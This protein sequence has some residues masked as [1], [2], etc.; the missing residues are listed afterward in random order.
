MPII[1]KSDTFKI[2][3][4]FFFTICLFWFFILPMVRSEAQV[5]IGE[6]IALKVDEGTNMAI[7]LSPDQSSIVLDLQGTLWMLPVQGGEATPL[8]DELGDCR[9]PVWAP[10]GNEIAFQSYRDGNYHIWKIN[11]DGSGLTQLTFGIFDDREP[12][13]APS[14]SSLLFSSD[15]S[16]NYDI[17]EL[18]LESGDLNQRTEDP[19]NDYYPSCS[20][21]GK[22]MVFV[23]DR[24]VKE[25]IYTKMGG[26]QEK[27]VFQDNGKLMAP[28]W[29]PGGERLVFNHQIGGESYLKSIDL[30]SGEVD[31]FSKPGED[32]FPF[33]VSWKSSES[34]LFTVD[35]KIKAAT[36]GE[37]GVK[38]IPFEANLPFSRHDYPRKRYDFLENKPKSVKGI[39]SPAVSPDGK[40]V[41]FTALGDLYVLDTSQ[42]EPQSLTNDKFIEIDPVWSPDG[43][44]V[45]YTSDKL[46][47]MD[48]WVKDLETGEETCLINE[49]DHVKFP[50]W[51]PDGTRIAFYQADPSAYR[52]SLLSIADLKSGTKVAVIGGLFDPGRATWSPDG[53]KIAYSSLKAYSSRF[54]EGISGIS[55][56]DIQSQTSEFMMP[57]PERTLGTRGVNGPTWSPDGSHLAF[58]LDNVLWTIPVD[59][60]GSFIGPSKRMTNELA[61]SPTW[62]GDG[63][64]LVY[65]ATDTL[66]QVFLEDGTRKSIPMTFDWNYD[67][68]IGQY[69]I[70]AGRIFDGKSETYLENMDVL[71][72]GNVIKSIEPHVGDREGKVIDASD[73]TLMPGLF[74]MHTHQNALA[75]EELGRLWLAYGITGI[76]EPGTDPYDALERKESWASGKRIGPRDFFTGGH[77]DGSRI[78]YNR[79]TS[80]HMGAEL[81]LELERAIRLEY[82]LLKTYVRM[83]DYMQKRVTAFA[84]KHGIPLSS[85]EIYPAAAYGVDAVEH[86]GATSRRGYSPKLTATNKTY[87]DVLTLIGHSGMVITP[88]VALHGGFYN[89]LLSDQEFLKNPQT[90]VFYTT[91]FQEGL[92]A[93][94]NRMAD[95]NPK[96]SDNFERIL[97]STYAI[98]QA[99][100][101]L[102]PGTDSSIIPPGISYHA[103]LQ[104]WVDAGLSPFEV[105]RAATIWSAE[106]LGVDNLLGTVEEGKIADLLILDGDPLSSI[107]ACLQIDRVIKNGHVYTLE[108]LLQPSK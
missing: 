46:G 23:S 49:E 82:D 55:M 37:P 97:Q 91:E 28:S 85:H 107:K 73:K 61:E 70:H 94:A 62:T 106:A 52:R 33:R 63:K 103:E 108:E 76:R 86:I 57:F 3:C 5:L 17:W 21:D 64:S 45:A 12:F 18:D 4:N 7:S 69:V 13:Y 34:F 32:V 30:N 47:N 67:H 84:H 79:S 39:R 71:I 80:S 11:K 9:Q 48:L 20:S 60:T 104:S 29:Q 8:T 75:G 26:E 95:A 58:T 41:I 78:Y 19:G 22:Q 43:K 98:F 88:T 102:N 101:R 65:L 92:K 93:N 50:S 24:N 59:A 100:G 68:P 16:G 1:I 14:G 40:Q 36:I 6:Q 53:K 83:P 42:G 31:L 66:K 54:R 74:E 35:G 15:R 87:A 51:S 77:M 25:E 72:E 96:F 2:N 38:V 89:R 10:N 56:V 27:S 90:Q 99:G 44:K 81:D 105:L